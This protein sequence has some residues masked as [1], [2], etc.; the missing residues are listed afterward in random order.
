MAAMKFVTPGKL[1]EDDMVDFTWKQK[2]PDLILMDGGQI[3]V[4][5]CED[6]CVTN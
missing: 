2:M 4:D 6:V 5:A 3:Q 1:L